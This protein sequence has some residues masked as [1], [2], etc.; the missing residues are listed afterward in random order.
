L[1][2][3]ALPDAPVP[4]SFGIERLN[5]LAEQIFEGEEMGHCVGSVDYLLG[6]VDGAVAIY[7]V[8]SPVRAT[9]ALSNCKQGYWEIGDLKGPHNAAISLEHFAQIAHAF[10]PEVDFDRWIQNR[11]WD[12]T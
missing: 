1:K 10:P 12:A 9:L 11:L 4:D 5:S 8:T 7:R 6:A 3:R 2:P